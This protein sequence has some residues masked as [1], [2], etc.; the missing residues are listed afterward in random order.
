MSDGKSQHKRNETN[1]KLF[2]NGIW[3]VFV[4]TIIRDLPKIDKKYNQN[5]IVSFLKETKI[6]RPT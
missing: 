1:N 2:L 4:F 6:F 5:Q 3:I